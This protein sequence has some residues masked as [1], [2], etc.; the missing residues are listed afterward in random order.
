MSNSPD[1]NHL[2]LHLFHLAL[3]HWEAIGA[4][5]HPLVLLREEFIK[6]R[7]G[8]KVTLDDHKHIRPRAS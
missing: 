2:A 5:A 6:L 8:T 1:L 7:Q 4:Y 3:H